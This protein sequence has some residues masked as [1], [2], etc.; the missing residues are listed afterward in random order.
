MCQLGQLMLKRMK[1]EWSDPCRPIRS[2]FHKTSFFKDC[3]P[4]PNCK[5][6]LWSCMFC[7]HS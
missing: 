7:V 4:S 1:L 3:T 6:N 2:K 5:M